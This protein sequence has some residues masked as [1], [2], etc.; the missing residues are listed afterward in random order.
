[1]IANFFKKSKPV[2]I[3]N[4]VVLLLGFYLV[5]IFYVGIAEFS[6]MLLI[7]KSVLFIF[8][9]LF[10]MIENFIVKKNNLTEDNLYTML[11]SVLLLG[12]FYETM[13]SKTILFSNILLLLRYRKIYSI[14]SGIDVGKKLFDAGLWIGAAALIYPPSILFGVLIF[15]AVI[16]YQKLYIQNFIIPLFGLATPYLLFFTYALYIEKIELFYQLFQFQ[17]SLD[18]T[19]YNQLKYL[20]PTTLVLAIT[21]WS[22]FVVTPKIVQISN[23]LRLSWNVLL[24]QLFIATILIFWAPIKNGSEVLFLLF[25]CVVIITNFIQKSQSKNFKNLILYLFLLVSIGVY[26]L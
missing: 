6:F 22:I 17:Y 20:I 23:T 21:T 24:A 25:P 16:I 1:M 11:L 15:L 7:K 4:L 10:L 14:K 13:F 2:N 18:F 3:F 8:L 5:S 19:A 9:F 26:F 12:S